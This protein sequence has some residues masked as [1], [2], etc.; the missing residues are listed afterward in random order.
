MDK[1]AEFGIAKPLRRLIGAQA[2]PIVAERT[3]GQALLDIDQEA[4][5]LA[6]VFAVG[7]NPLSI[8]LLRRQRICG[9]SIRIIRMT[10]SRLRLDLHREESRADDD[11]RGKRDGETSVFHWSLLGSGV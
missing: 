2:L 4:F 10:R 5:S 9:R 3:A 6:I 11:A 1:N 8:D 7:L